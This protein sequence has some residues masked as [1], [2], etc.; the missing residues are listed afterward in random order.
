MRQELTKPFSWIKASMSAQPYG[1][2]LGIFI[3]FRLFAF[4]YF[5]GNYIDSDQ[6]VLARQA[7]DFARGQ[8]HSPYFYGQGYN[9]SIEALLSAPLIAF[10]TPPLWALPLVTAVLSAL[11]WVL[12]SQLPQNPNQRAFVLLSSFL[13]PVSYT[14]I[15]LLPRGFVQ[16]LAL[17]AIGL[18]AFYKNVPARWSLLTLCSALA[19]MAN[20]N[21]LLLLALAIPSLLRE[22]SSKA[23]LSSLPGWALA[24]AFYAALKN[25]S[26]VL[27]PQW[28]HGMPN[29]S[30]EWKALGQHL[31]VLP[32]LMAHLNWLPGWAGLALGL[33]FCIALLH[34]F[35]QG[36]AGIALLL[37]ILL[38]LGLPKLG[39]G[40]GHIFYSYGRFFLGL[41]LAIALASALGT[42][43]S[44][45]LRI[46]L[47]LLVFLT[48]S[49]ALWEFSS[50]RHFGLVYSPVMV[51]HRAT[52]QQHAHEVLR[53]SES[54]DCV[55]VGN[56]WVIEAGSQGYGLV[57]DLPPSYR[58]VYER[59]L[60]ALNSDL[61]KAV[62]EL[63]LLD[64][65]LEEKS[66]ILGHP[67]LIWNRIPSGLG[68]LYQIRS[69]REKS[70]R[71]FLQ[72]LQLDSPSWADPKPAP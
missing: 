3:A 59:R 21:A 28:V 60:F 58:P 35:Q 72:I 44:F 22:C 41:P 10:G 49:Y 38:S 9:L 17:A 66:D 51:Y 14:Q 68:T 67:D 29:L 7:W 25:W 71:E 40:T 32:D 53:A 54:S 46:P 48:Y 20:P 36:W 39:D 23:L 70:L 5:N 4:A 64:V 6:C 33:V 31:T 56:H 30:W 63:L 15:S 8:W 27:S 26:Q 69:K 43:P 24:G 50:I 11:P 12:F 37:A 34:R 1:W 55:I 16:G 42:W 47:W 52:F 61:D 2:A 18:Y 19:M 62:D 57:V 65:E 13:W 45:R